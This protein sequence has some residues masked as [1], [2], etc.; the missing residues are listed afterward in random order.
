MRI[1]RIV[2]AVV[3]LLL[4]TAVAAEAAERHYRHYVAL[5][6]SYTSGPLIPL[7]RLDPL[8][9]FRSTSNYP[10]MLAAGLS[11]ERFTDVSC[12]GADTGD[13]TQQQNVLLGVNPPQFSALRPDTDLVTLGIGGNDSGLF[14]TLIN[15]C[16][17]LRASD[18]AGNPCQRHFTVDGVD[19]IKALLPK[20]QA[21]IGKVLAGIHARAPQAEVLAIGYPRI[22][23]AT[24]YCDDLPFAQGDYAWLSSVEEALNAAIRNAVNTD[25]RS[26]FVDTYGPSAGHDACQAP[27][28]AWINGK[29]LK[30]LAAAPYHPVWAGMAG[31]TQVIR[32][33]LGS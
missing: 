28:V 3:A 18:P 14:G 12:G 33:Q 30:V 29:D 20:T 6:D 1:V 16:P 22:A 7:P 24:G 15:T 9:C 27:G 4:S 11:V 26:V 32:Q 21:S 25:G 31:V 10:S 5:G 17:G 2:L 23:P 19:T 13:M 8:G